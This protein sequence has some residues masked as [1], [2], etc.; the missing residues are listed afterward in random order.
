M[1]KSRPGAGEGGL[2]IPGASASA[3]APL[4]PPPRPQG[5]VSQRKEYQS[6]TEFHFC[7][8]SVHF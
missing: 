4:R 8:V 3:S 2:R 1:R 6:K 7:S 5:W